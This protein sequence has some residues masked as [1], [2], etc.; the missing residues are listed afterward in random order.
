MGVP[1]PNVLFPCVLQWIVM[2]DADMSVRINAPE[3]S[4][5]VSNHNYWFVNASSAVSL[6][7]MGRSNLG[8]S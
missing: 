8:H 1:I 4:S 2:Y 3:P 5:S 6:S 7:C